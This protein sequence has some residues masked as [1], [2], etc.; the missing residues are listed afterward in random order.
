MER[1]HQLGKVGEHEGRYIKGGTERDV[2]VR[3]EFI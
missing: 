1:D 2:R 3:V